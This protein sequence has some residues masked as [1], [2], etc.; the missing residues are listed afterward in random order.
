MGARIM[1]EVPHV[2]PVIDG[3]WHFTYLTKWPVPGD[4]VTTLCGLSEPA[5][6][7]NN[8]SQAVVRTCW[9]CD[10]IYRR[11]AGIPW[12]GPTPHPAA[13]SEQQR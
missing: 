11:E 13:L 3:K 10:F 6:Y 5:E 7:D 12:Y 2:R 1:V 4:T 9:N 8:G